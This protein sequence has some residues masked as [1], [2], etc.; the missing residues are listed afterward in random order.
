ME[1]SDQLDKVCRQ[2]DQLV[3][4]LFNTLDSLYSEQANLD[5]Q[6]KDGYL[7]MSKARYTMG[8]KAVSSLQYD[9]RNMQAVVKVDAV[10]PSVDG[11]GNDYVFSLVKC[12]EKGEGIAP[13]GGE[14]DATSKGL[15]HRNVKSENVKDSGSSDQHDRSKKEE[16][17]TCELENK[18]STENE[19][20]ANDNKKKSEDKV[21][22]KK[23]NNSAVRCYDPLKWFGV[24]VPQSLRQSQT[25]FKKAIE[26]ACKIAELRTNL[27]KTRMKYGSLL[28]QKKELQAEQ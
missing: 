28:Q 8:N 23:E 4:D 26:T 7:Q 24:L 3:L 14:G 6:M 22:S 9:T 10:A 11:G 27:E 2:L 19:K 20:C 15:R 5:L 25:D 16:D 13:S 21:S 12:G 17:E 1:D 18:E